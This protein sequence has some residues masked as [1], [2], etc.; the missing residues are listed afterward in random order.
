MKS[1]VM[2]ALALVLAVQ[3]PAALAQE[4]RGG[5][6]P[7]RS[8]WR[9]GGGGRPDGAGMRAQREWSE[10]RERRSDD[11]GRSEAPR[12]REAPQAPQAV[13]APQPAQPRVRAEGG[14]ARRTDDGQRWQGRRDEGGRAAVYRDGRQTGD[15]DRWAGRR[16]DD[17][18]DGDRRD[19][20]RD[21]D[22]R[23]DGRRDYDGRYGDR[24]YD[25]RRWD[26]R[27][28]Y[29]GDYRRWERG[30]YPSVYFSTHRYRYA[31]RPPV[32]F[33]LRTWS[34]GDFFP[35][36]WYGPDY[37]I[38]DPWM[39]DLPLPP[40]GFEWVRSGPDALLIDEYTGR[41]VQVVRNVFWY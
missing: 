4:R 18:R 19:W 15:R 24:R 2:T 11:R 37:W 27:R 14:Q 20:R 39:Y 10:T 25:D 35:R 16:D 30:R 40:P 33:Y 3:A 1:L 13:Q 5:D 8:E 17:R 41:I 6:R 26:G 23:W 7:E 34:Y 21:S 38:I 29:R 22:R 36:G 32:G 28:D 9:G 31:W 12:A